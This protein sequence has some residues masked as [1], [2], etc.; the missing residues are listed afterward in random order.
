MELDE[1]PTDHKKGQIRLVLKLS[2][3]KLEMGIINFE[4]KSI[5]IERTR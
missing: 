4:V 2:N 1:Y 5:T 3:H